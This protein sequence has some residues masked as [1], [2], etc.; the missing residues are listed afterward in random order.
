M[1]ALDRI[2]GGGGGGWVGELKIRPTPVFRRKKQ[3]RNL[4][5]FLRSGSVCKAKLVWSKCALM[6][7]GGGGG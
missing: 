1:R 3:T 6:M 4:N 7:G 5:F 2:H